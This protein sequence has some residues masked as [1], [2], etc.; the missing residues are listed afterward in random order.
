MQVLEQ[1]KAKNLQGSGI[2]NA[3]LFPA[4]YIWEQCMRFDV[5]A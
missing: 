1:E 3:P 2:M 4:S 5:N